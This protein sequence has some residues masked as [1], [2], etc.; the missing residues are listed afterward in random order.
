MTFSIADE[1]VYAPLITQMMPSKGGT[2]QVID[3]T[4]KETQLGKFSPNNGGEVEFFTNVQRKLGLN[5]LIIKHCDIYERLFD[6]RL[7]IEVK[8]NS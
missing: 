8:R 1:S 2:T 5:E 4:G 3:Q 6:L 7:L